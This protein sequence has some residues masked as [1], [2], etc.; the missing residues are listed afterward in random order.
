MPAF[1]IADVTVTDA[2]QMAKYREWSTKAMQEHGA[3]VLVRGGTIEVL[4]GDW[5]PSRLVVLKFPDRAAAR[6]FYESETYQHAKSLRQQ[7]GVMRMVVVDG[8]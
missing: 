5:T 6:R 1:I 8:V 2:D 7:A 3:E 4:E